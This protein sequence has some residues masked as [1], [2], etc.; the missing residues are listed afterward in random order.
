M[1]ASSLPAHAIKASRG[2]YSFLSRLTTIFN[3]DIA[4]PTTPLTRSN[5]SPS[6][7]YISKFTIF[8][9]RVSQYWKKLMYKS[10]N[11]TPEV[12]E[13]QKHISAHLQEKPQPQEIVTN[14]NTRNNIHTKDGDVLLDHH[15]RDNGAIR[16][17]QLSLSVTLREYRSAFSVLPR[18]RLLVLHVTYLIRVAAE[19]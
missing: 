7:P 12:L 13:K 9:F 4:P 11:Q 18:R 16:G 3:I 10:Y 2:E 6:Y 8:N 14:P 17:F 5:N 1:E 19:W 15:S